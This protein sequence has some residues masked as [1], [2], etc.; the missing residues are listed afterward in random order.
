MLSKNCH[1]PITRALIE[2]QSK[3]FEQAFARRYAKYGIVSELDELVQSRQKVYIFSGVIRD[4]FLQLDSVSRDVDIVI[5]GKT[6]DHIME[7][8]TKVV[9]QFGG[10]KIKKD[11]LTIDMWCL[12]NTWGI[13]RKK[14]NSTP[15]ELIKTSFFNF[16]AILYDYRNHQFV[17]GDDFLTFL[18]SRVLDYV[19]EDNPYPALCVVNTLYYSNKLNCGISDRL[20]KW[21]KRYATEM[22]FPDYEDIQR[23]HFGEVLYDEQAI[24]EFIK[25]IS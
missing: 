18:N 11:G 19:Y 20:K 8:A 10:A 12:T 25:S 9:N 22:M 2:A 15:D 3:E 24:K 16:S 13:K 5:S 1:T 17:V 4:Y 7:N 21:I 23:K 6:L 14:V